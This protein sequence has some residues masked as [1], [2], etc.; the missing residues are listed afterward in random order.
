MLL[1][2]RRASLLVTLLACASVLASGSSTPDCLYAFSQ[3]DEQVAV[4]PCTADELG[5]GAD[6]QV[7]AAMRFFGITASAVTF[8]SC[9]GGRF[10]A[11]PH[12]ADS[13]RFVV[14]YPSSAKSDYLAAVVH[15]L[16]HIVQ[17]RAA[18]G[19]KELDPKSNSRRIELGA[20][21]LAGL[22]FNGPLRRLNKG[23][24]ES[25]LN[26]IGSYTATKSEDHGLPAHR[27]QA[28][29]L[30]AVRADPYPELNTAQALEYFYG[31]D[32]ARITP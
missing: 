27:A 3:G 12:G 16:A 28:F 11:R 6:S 20:D 30:G 15:E 25:S 1:L 7:Q 23:N 13:T 10:S 22:A 4:A 2:V 32:Y 18:G 24:F 19:L 26:L 31:N 8:R 17:I 14:D 29:R 9:P 21:F 5:I